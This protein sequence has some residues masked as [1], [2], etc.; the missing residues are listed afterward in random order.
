MNSEYTYKSGIVPCK[1]LSGLYIA[2]R[3]GHLWKQKAGIA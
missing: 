1:I 3:A 2:D